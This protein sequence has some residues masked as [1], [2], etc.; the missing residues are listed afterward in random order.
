MSTTPSRRIQWADAEGSDLNQYSDGNPATKFHSPLPDS[1]RLVSLSK[2]RA[3]SNDQ[4]NAQSDGQ[5]NG[6]SNG[7]FAAKSNGKFGGKITMNGSNGHRD[8][9]DLSTNPW[10]NALNDT[11]SG[12]TKKS[13][14]SKQSKQSAKPSKSEGETTKFDPKKLLIPKQRKNAPDFNLL[15]SKDPKQIEQIYKTLN[16]G[17]DESKSDNLAKFSRHNTTSEV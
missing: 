8:D 4:S 12:K 10:L 17:E 2:L 13:E 9:H 7:Q 14:K 6:P 3:Q 15:G 5:S 11:K 1:I 16:R